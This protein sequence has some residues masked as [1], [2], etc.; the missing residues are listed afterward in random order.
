[1]PTDSQRRNLASAHHAEVQTLKERI[2]ELENDRNYW[3]ELAYFLEDQ[4]EWGPLPK[5][6]EA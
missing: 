6:R 1:M 3:R 5:D 2:K 4:L